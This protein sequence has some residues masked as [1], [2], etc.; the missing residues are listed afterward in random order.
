MVVK[1]MFSDLVDEKKEE[2]L[3]EFGIERP[4]EMNMDLLPLAIIEKDTETEK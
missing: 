4:E 2:V 1:I 3:K